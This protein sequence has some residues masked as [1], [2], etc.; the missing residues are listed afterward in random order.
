MVNNVT[1]WMENFVHIL[2]VYLWWSICIF[3]DWR[4]SSFQQYSPKSLRLSLR[5]FCYLW[6]EKGLSLM[7]TLSSFNKFEH[8]EIKKKK[9]RLN[10]LNI[11]TGNLG[12][13]VVNPLV[14]NSSFPV[15]IPFI[16]HQC[17]QWF[18]L[19]GKQIFGSFCLR[20]VIKTSDTIKPMFKDCQKNP[21]RRISSTKFLT[22][23]H[24]ME[25]GE[26]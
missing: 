17:L 23:S 20:K 9:K 11:I 24:D 3:S 15:F 12:R 13:Q 4:V 10:S 14:V 8:L 18:L 16:F 5:L 26:G 6:E 21:E 1:Q 2:Q 19:H 25:L 22:S 7:Q